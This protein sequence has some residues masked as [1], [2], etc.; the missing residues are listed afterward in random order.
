MKLQD[1]IYEDVRF[2]VLEDLDVI[3]GT[4]LQEQHESIVIKY[5]GDE[6]SLTF[7]ALASLAA[8]PTFL[9][10]N[11]TE[12]CRPIAT[13]SLRHSSEDREFIESETKRLL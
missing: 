4:D 10:A 1:R 7:C 12:D 13:K 5:G 8:E 6:P 3:L 11:L 2:T 9:F